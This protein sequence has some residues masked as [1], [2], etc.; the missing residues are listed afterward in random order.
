[1]Q[2]RP[3]NYIIGP[4]GY[5][6]TRLAQ[7]L[8]EALPDA[9]FIGLD[10]MA[11]GGASARSRLNADAAL[12]LRVEKAADWLVEDGA[13]ISD[14][15][16][17][18]LTELEAESPAVLVIDMIEQGLD[19]ATQAALMTHLQRRGESGRR[20]FMLTR[21]SAILD[22][23]AVGTNEAIIHC[24]ANHSP[25]IL[26]APFPG[27][28]GYESVAA[29]LASPEVRARTDGVIAIRSPV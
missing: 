13:T 26:V 5:G 2:I 29:C 8:A 1:M 7:K 9:A 3:L 24:P 17:V 19:E 25:P 12:R 4:L 23:E 16:I 27:A 22:L 10:R 14:A 20:F 15:L 28:R 21:S 6:K 11:D 18:L